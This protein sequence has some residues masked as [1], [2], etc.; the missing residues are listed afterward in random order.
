LGILFYKR[1]VV[2]VRKGDWRFVSKL[3]WKMK[4][5]TDVVD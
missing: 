5:K 2:K 3:N 4:A 1:I